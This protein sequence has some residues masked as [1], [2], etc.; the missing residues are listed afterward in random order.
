MDVILNCN[1]K[2]KVTVSYAMQAQKEGR[3]IDPSHSQPGTRER[4]VVSTMF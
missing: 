4:W 2:V 3:I 1:V